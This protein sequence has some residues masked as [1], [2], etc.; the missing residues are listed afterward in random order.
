MPFKDFVGINIGIYDP[1]ES[2]V[3]SQGKNTNTIGYEPKSVPSSPF[4]TDA[5]SAGTNQNISA[6]TETPA[7]NFLV[8]LNLH[9]NGAWS[10]S[11]WSQTRVSHCPLVRNQI[12]NNTYSFYGPGE[13]INIQ[14]FDYRQRYGNLEFKTEPMVTS[15]FNPLQ[16]NFGYM[17][18]DDRLAEFTLRAVLANECRS[19][20]NDRMSELFTVK[21]LTTDDYEQAKAMYLDNALNNSTNPIDSIELVKY[22]E[23]IYPQESNTFLSR[24][25]Q[26]DK[27]VSGFWRSNREER[28]YPLSR[29]HG[30]DPTI[31]AKYTIYDP[32]HPVTS[33]S[34]WCL[35]RRLLDDDVFIGFD[36]FSTS[37]SNGATFSGTNLGVDDG[38]GIL[39]NTFSQFAFFDQTGFS[40]TGNNLGAKAF[41]HMKD[42]PTYYH[43]HA[44]ETTASLVSPS[45]MTVTMHGS[46]ISPSFLFR[47]DAKFVTPATR[48]IFSTSPEGVRTIVPA[49]RE[50]FYDT[51]NK[52]AEYIKLLGKDY[53]IVPEFIISENIDFYLNAG[54]AETNLPFLTVKGAKE[55]TDVPI[56][57]ARQT[58]SVNTDLP[59]LKSDSAEF[60]NTYT[61]S[62]FLKMFDVVEVD[63]KDTLEPSV[64]KLTCKAIKKFRPHDGFYPAARTTQL[65]Q[66]FYDSY[67]D[68]IETDNGGVQ[69]LYDTQI[70]NLPMRVEMQSASAW[71]ASTYPARIKPINTALFSPGIMYN[72][73][74]A[75][76][77]CDWPNI[78][79]Y[80]NHT[81]ASVTKATD[82]SNASVQTTHT[83]LY[84]TLVGEAELQ[85]LGVTDFHLI[86]PANQGTAP[87]YHSYT[88]SMPY[89]HN[90]IPFE[91]IVNP[92]GHLTAY[93]VV[94]TEAHPQGNTGLV[95]K[96]GGGAKDS[97]YKL[98]A[99]NFFAE[100]PRFF[101]K[102]KRFSTFQS[103][104]QGDPNFGI[105]SATG[106]FYG[107][108]LKIRRSMKTTRVQRETE[109]VNSG[110]VVKS[111]FVPQD[112][113][114]EAESLTMYSRPSAFGPATCGI[115]GPHASDNFSSPYP[116]SYIDNDEYN[117]LKGYNFP[118]TPPYYHGEAWCDIIFLPPSGAEGK[119]TIEQIF[120][121]SRI[122]QLRFWQGN[123]NEFGTKLVD[124]NGPATGTTTGSA[125]LSHTISE[126]LSGNLS[127]TPSTNNNGFVSAGMQF[128]LHPDGGPITSPINYNAMQ[129]SSS[130]NILTKFGSEDDVSSFNLGPLTIETNTDNDNDARWIIQSKFETPILNFNHV[131][132]DDLNLTDLKDQQLKSVAGRGLWHQHGRIPA[133][134]E[135]VFLEICDIPEEWFEE[136][137]ISIYQASW[138][139]NTPGLSS[140]SF[141]TSTEI[142]SLA[143]LVGF[144]KNE[145]I[146]MGELAERKTIKE[147]VIAVPFKEVDGRR[148]YFELDR[149]DVED[150]LEF[151][152]SI[153]E[154]KTIS[155]GKSIVN[156]ITA[157]RDYVIPPEMDFLSDEN[158][159][160]FAMY[161][162]EFTH[163]LTKQ[164]LSDIWQNTLP[165]IGIDHELAETEISHEL[166]SNELLGTKRKLS[167]ASKLITND[168]QSLFD[169]D[170]QWMVFKVKQQAHKSYSNLIY[171]N[172]KEEVGTTYNWPYDYFSLVELVKLEAEVEL[173]D[174]QE[175]DETRKPK[176]ITSKRFRAAG[177]DLAGD[178]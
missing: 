100:I 68:S 138:N 48:T 92:E 6:L 51:Y 31:A 137:K 119:L 176:K 43:R 24:T 93:S 86:R 116:T 83:G 124:E 132:E 109:Q 164:D 154:E 29:E 41:P 15:K 72:T 147:A 136:T 140:P 97:K 62:D 157:M 128:S 90:R 112:H 47:G 30:F 173:S 152:E 13:F 94:D 73:I 98:M 3:G 19:F 11:S 40:A 9:R 142:K 114:D 133:G 96:L 130:V 57:G 121:N 35:D 139:D 168:K 45:G 50:P 87:D 144:P 146:R 151:I 69:V 21:Q 162:F 145:P 82:T 36:G 91:A 12:K 26:R 134:D 129:V 118:F 77:A 64:L 14:G 131:T 148:N 25:K 143:D 81:N 105:L 127:Q 122:F 153:N 149:K 18:K 67:S 34:S 58:V 88:D 10:Y 158:I 141:P 84:T 32:S 22:V 8:I 56:S 33:P 79:A 123:N 165:D 111:L 23:N 46:P 4:Y 95:N 17:L 172:T 71:T 107:M 75:G 2:D 163:E 101:L 104:R 44:T 63:N 117:H 99:N 171:G 160:P 74:K 115:S 1:I 161:I 38:S 52:Y 110:S 80:Y 5:V 89:F 55:G 39:Q 60:Y 120:N 49:E 66:Q 178:D 20:T 113:P 102:R 159:Q 126:I 37:G 76:I 166:L 135:G 150:T 108:R 54:A 61:N 167:N 156:Q 125:I 85:L 103:L 170:I 65:A 42:A 16:Y 155:V 174:I 169:S 28:E 7:A 27:Y 53:S 78:Q 106:S 59:R 175:E 70:S 177:T